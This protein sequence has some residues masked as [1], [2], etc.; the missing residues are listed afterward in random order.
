LEVVAVVAVAELPLQVL[1]RVGQQGFL[2][3]QVQV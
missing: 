2:Q 1:L 3:V